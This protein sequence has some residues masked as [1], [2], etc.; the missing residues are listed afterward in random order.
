[1]TTNRR[2]KVTTP[3]GFELLEVLPNG[4][5]V[6]VN[7]STQLEATEGLG[8]LYVQETDPGMTDPG[9]WVELNPDGTPHTV[10]IEDGV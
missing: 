7:D 1:M 2:L 3:T 5:V 6:S 8:D 10:W 9:M 4:T